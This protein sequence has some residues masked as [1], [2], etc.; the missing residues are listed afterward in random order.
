MRGHY[1]HIPIQET[2]KRKDDQVFKIECAI[3]GGAYLVD[4][5]NVCGT[6]GQVDLRSTQ[7]V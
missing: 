4:T 2:E 6:V 5:I 7:C 1:V 3:P